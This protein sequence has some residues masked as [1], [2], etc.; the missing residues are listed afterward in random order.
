[1][2]CPALLGIGGYV[3]LTDVNLETG[4]DLLFY[5]YNGRI[6]PH[7]DIRG[8]L[9]LAKKYNIPVRYFKTIVGDT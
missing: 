6:K 9:T 1:V 3:N 7:S 2:R 5:L 8:L 4:R